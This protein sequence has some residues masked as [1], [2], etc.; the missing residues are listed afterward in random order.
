MT[1]TAIV[2]GV[3]A[4]LVVLGVLGL[5]AL[6]VLY[7]LASKPNRFAV[8]DMTLDDVDDY[9]ERRAAFAI[10]IVETTPLPRREVWERLTEAPYLSSLPLLR[11]PEWSV[12]GSE[13]VAVG[14]TRTMSGTVLSVSQ[15]LADVEERER[16]VLI[17]TGVSVPFAIKNFAERFTLTDGERLNTITV[18]WE[19]AGSPKWVGFLPWRWGAPLIR[20]VL[21]FVLR[22]I[23]RLKPFRRPGTTA[24]RAGQSSPS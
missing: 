14:A 6:F 4:V 19:I 2:V 24:G 5:L 10:T 20:P 18:T 11:G 15:R 8:R 16:I 22:H 3:V 7:G 12:S 17:G 23:L 9:I 21:A 13:R 1:A